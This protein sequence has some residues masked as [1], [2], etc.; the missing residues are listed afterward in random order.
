LTTDCFFFF[1]VDND[2]FLKLNAKMY[3]HWFYCVTVL[4]VLRLA[5]IEGYYDELVIQISWE[6]NCTR[7]PPVI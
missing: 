6:Q 1:A 2:T 3:I 7:K 4:V 5:L